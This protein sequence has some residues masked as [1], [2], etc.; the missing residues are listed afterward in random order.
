[1][2]AITEY[3]NSLC[4]KISSGNID[5]EMSLSVSLEN[6]TIIVAV[7]NSG[8]FLSEIFTEEIHNLLL[9][10]FNITYKETK[11][12]KE[13]VGVSTQKFNTKFE[14]RLRPHIYSN[15]LRKGGLENLL[16]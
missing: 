10:L 2:D 11:A 5:D 1:M 4:E 12:T 15:I 3:L 7:L 14:C 9:N 16:D 13:V 8:Y 6:D